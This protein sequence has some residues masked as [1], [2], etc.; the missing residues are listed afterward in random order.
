MSHAQDDFFD[1]LFAGFLNGQVQ[2]RN[3]AFRTVERKGFSARKFLTNEFFERDRIGQARQDS[4]L[5]LARELKPVFRGFH[6]ALQP[7]S[8][9]EVVD[10][11]VLHADRTAVRIA[12]PLEQFAQRQRAVVLKRLAVHR[13]IHVGFGEAK[14]FRCEFGRHGPRQPQRVDL[15][16]AVTAHPI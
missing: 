9:A 14:E 5:L 4:Q 2:Q 11:H 8:H 1:S 12:Q 7:A 6:A 15:R 16:D 10:V 3:Q 13:R